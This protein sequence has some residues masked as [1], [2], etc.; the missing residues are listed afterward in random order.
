MSLKVKLN[1][2]LFILI[3]MLFLFLNYQQVFS[4]TYE[5]DTF[6]HILLLKQYFNENKYLPHPMWHYGTYIVSGLFQTTYENSAV[7]FSTFIMAVWLLIIQILTERMDIHSYSYQKTIKLFTVLI[8]IF[9]G[10]LIL[11]PYDY[12]IYQGK[13]SPNIWHNITLWM[14]KPFAILSII[15]LIYAQKEDSFKYYLIALI[16]SVLSLFAK[17]SF[18]L[19]FLPALFILT[20]FNKKLLWQKSFLLFLASLTFFSFLILQYQF[21]HT[22]SESEII[23]DFLGVWSSSSSNILLSIVLALAFPLLFLLFQQN[24]LKELK[25]QLLWIQLILSILLYAFFAQSGK[26]YFHANFSWSY[27]ITMSLLY[28]FS[29]IKFITEYHLIPIYKRYLLSSILFLQTLVG[30]YYFINIL[31]GK[32]P[33]YIAVFF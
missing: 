25:F 5:S 2:S 15:S 30:V 19:V 26:Q 21:S 27:M 1:I 4:G 22:F 17:P 20:I 24:Q 29:I 33:I 32:N 7:V 13:G 10:P 8:I 28:V 18:V 14:L 3:S 9:I 6:E 11:P 31:Q 23:F 16:L 12:I